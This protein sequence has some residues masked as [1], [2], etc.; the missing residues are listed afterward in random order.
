MIAADAP[1]QLSGSQLA[2]VLAC[3]RQWFLARKAQGESARNPAATFG[4]VVHVLAEYGAQPDADVASLTG[5]LDSVW[6]QL[7]FDANWLSAAERLEAEAAVERFVAWHQ[8]R[9]KQELLGTEVEFGFD[10]TVDGERVRLTGTAD[11]VERDPDGRIRIVDFKTSRVG[12]LGIRRCLAG[13]AR[14]LPAGGRRRRAGQDRRR[15]RPPRWGRTGLSPAPRRQRGLSAGLPPVLAGRS[16]V[17]SR[18]RAGPVQPRH[19]KC[20]RVRR[21]GST[22]GWPRQPS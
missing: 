15:R 6:D 3:P 8:A 18:P 21:P 17:P 12:S 5:H 16:P 19:D 11:R 22:A 10:I 1:I 9:S 7:D 2:N 13:P 4:S 14:R 20:R